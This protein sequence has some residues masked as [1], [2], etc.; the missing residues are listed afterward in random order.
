MRKVLIGAAVVAALAGVFHTQ[1]RA[2]TIDHCKTLDGYG[3]S[4]FNPTELSEYQECWLDVYKADET[5]GTLGS[6]FWVKVDGEYLSMPV[7]K[8]HKAGS[9]AKAKEIIIKEVTKVVIEERLVEVFVEDLTRIN[10]LQAQID[11]LN[12]TIAT[13]RE[14]NNTYAQAI[15]L[16]A[17]QRDNLQARIDNMFTQ[18]DLDRAEQLAFERGLARSDVIN[19]VRLRTGVSEAFNTEFNE[20]GVSG[21]GSMIRR[22][23]DFR[24]AYTDLATNGFHVSRVRAVVAAAIDVAIAQ[25]PSTVPTL[26]HT[27]NGGTIITYGEARARSGGNYVADR[28]DTI[29]ANSEDI[30]NVSRVTNGQS[31]QFLLNGGNVAGLWAVTEANLVIIEQAIEVAYDSGYS[32]GYNDGYED[33]YQDGFRDGF[34]AAGGDI[35]S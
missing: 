34:D 30:N 23:A 17:E 32:D 8:I 35:N 31:V 2:D 25:I 7:K 6:I 1:V 26:S 13:L 16:L 5:A 15:I 33:G 10:E 22:D 28:D 9:A 14:E 29:A 21:L 3:E 12:T 11:G 18:A 4:R 27:L 24:A 20:L 19:A